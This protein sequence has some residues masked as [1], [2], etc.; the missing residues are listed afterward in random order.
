MVRVRKA[1]R[2]FC[3]GSPP[4]RRH[5]SVSNIEE[6]KAVLVSALRDMPGT[7]VSKLYATLRHKGYSSQKM[8]Q[9][10]LR[11][12]IVQSV[13]YKTSEKRWT[14]YHLVTER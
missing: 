3:R 13:V 1:L 5:T 9:R 14:R 4:P 12:L 8:V 11:S 2:S 6:R 10:D 7:S